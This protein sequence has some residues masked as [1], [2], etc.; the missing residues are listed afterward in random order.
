MDELLNQESTL[1]LRFNGRSLDFPLRDL[2][3]GQRADDRAIK[4]AVSRHLDVNEADLR[5]YTVDRH[6]TG[7]VTIRPEAIFG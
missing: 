6:Q 2:G 3:I 1:H 4:I 5:D 7:N